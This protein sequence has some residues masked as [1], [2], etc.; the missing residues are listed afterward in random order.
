VYNGFSIAVVIPAYNEEELIGRTIKRIPPFV[1]RIIVIDDSS[2]DSTSEVARS[3][4][5]LRTRIVR[6]TTNQGVGGAIV[7]GYKEVLRR[8]LDVAVVMAGDG[9]MDP[10]D[11]PQLLDPIAAGTADYVKGNRFLHP[12][13]FSTM[14][15]LRFAGNLALSLLT[16]GAAGYF[17]IMDS[18]CGYTAVTTDT[19][20]RLH[21]DRVYKRYGFPNDF[22]AHLHS[23]RCRVAQV[24]VRP[25]YEE[26]SSGINPLFA[27]AP[28][29]YV[30][31]RAF[32]MRVHRERLSMSQH[33]ES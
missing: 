3:V 26:E 6:H 23:I 10:A 8:G 14:P 28:L 2:G 22:L 25:V 1:D 30:L 11:L 13:V 4:S 29:G 21:L 31:A 20:A 33:A 24:A 17:D 27:I 16:R 19:L 18:Q 32:V 5:D 9:Q 12:A 15:R 7:T